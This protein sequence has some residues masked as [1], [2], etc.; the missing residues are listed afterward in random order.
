M[1]ISG[2]LIVHAPVQQ[3]EEDLVGR[4]I[5]DQ[6][7]IPPEQVSNPRQSNT[8][9]A[10][11][12]NARAVDWERSSQEEEDRAVPRRLAAAID[13]D[14]ALA[15]EDAPGMLALEE[16]VEYLQRT[17]SEEVASA[18]VHNLKTVMTV[19]RVSAPRR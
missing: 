16:A 1:V 12:P 9:A 15:G 17:G 8:D 6:E 11:Q 14:L 19:A 3:Q 4:S 18:L 10:K 2:R 7:G 13:L 5:E